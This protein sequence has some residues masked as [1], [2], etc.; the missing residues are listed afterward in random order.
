MTKEESNA[1]YE[2]R[3]ARREKSN[4]SAAAP[5]FLPRRHLLDATP[6]S[7]FIP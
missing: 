4:L 6:L 5:S 3:K 7:S 1:A 2:K